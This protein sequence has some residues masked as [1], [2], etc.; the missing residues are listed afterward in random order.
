MK[1][2]IVL[3]PDKNT[4]FCIDGLFTRC[5]S[6]NIRQIQYE[7]YIHPQHDPGVY[8]GAANFLR[9]FLSQFSFAL[10]F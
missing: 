5:D 1:D 10:V 2:L 4:K 6:L 9:P 8:L 3:A 7:I